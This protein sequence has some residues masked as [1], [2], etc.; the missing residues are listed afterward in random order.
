MCTKPEVVLK[1]YLKEIYIISLKLLQQE[2]STTSFDNP[3]QRST[4]FTITKFFLLTMLMP[5][6]LQ[7]NME[8]YNFQFKFPMFILTFSM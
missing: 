5:L 8:Y 6:F 4:A 2:N 3:F 1:R 7:N